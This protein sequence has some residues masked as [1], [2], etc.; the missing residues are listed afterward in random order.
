MLNTTIQHTE[1]RKHSIHKAAVPF[2]VYYLPEL[3]VGLTE[4]F[5]TVVALMTGGCT[6]EN[7]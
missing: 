5:V 4:E 6:S 3:F 2:L 7:W 1:Q